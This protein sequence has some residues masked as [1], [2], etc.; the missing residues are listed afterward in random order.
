MPAVVAAAHLPPVLV[1]LVAQVRHPVS[2]ALLY[3][4]PEVVA[5]VSTPG[6]VLEDWAAVVRVAQEMQ[7]ATLAP[8]IWEVAVAV[9]VIMISRI[10]KPVATAARSRYHFDLR[11]GSSCEYNREPD[12]HYVRRPPHLQVQ[13]HRDD[14]I[15]V[16]WPTSRKS[17]PVTS[18]SE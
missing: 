13:R 7:P 10:P 18:S 14:Y 2:P 8:L 11:N 6:A 15:P 12:R 9:A 4:M 5:A 1:R 17:I 16:K 3:F